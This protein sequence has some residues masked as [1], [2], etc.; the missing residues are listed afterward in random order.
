MG[1]AQKVR[2]FLVVVGSNLRKAFFKLFSREMG[3]DDGVKG[4]VKLGV[5]TESFEVFERSK[6]VGLITSRDQI[7]KKNFLSRRVF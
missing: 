3:D 4:L 5:M 6:G 1:P 2:V 7:G